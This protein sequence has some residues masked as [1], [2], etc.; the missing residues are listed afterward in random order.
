MDILMEPIGISGNAVPS[1]PVVTQCETSSEKCNQ[2]HL[3]LKPKKGFLQRVNYLVSR[4]FHSK[5]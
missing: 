2:G 1:E 4:F 5:L 3:V